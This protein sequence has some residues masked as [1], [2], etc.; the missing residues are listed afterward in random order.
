[1]K[2]VLAGTMAGRGGIQTHY[3]WLSRALLEGGHSVRVLSLGPALDGSDK[4]RETELAAF[5]D[6]EVICPQFNADKARV[7]PMA[8]GLRIL[9]FLRRWKPD[10]YLAC[11][12]GWNLFLP[13]ILGLRSTRT[14]HE[15]MSGVPT[16]RKDSRWAVRFGFNEVLAQAGPVGENFARHFGWKRPITVLPA[17]PEP[18]EVTG[19]VPEGVTHTVPFG[20][21]KAAF[22]SRLVPHKGALWLV[23]QW[24]RLS[25]SLK[26]L[27]IFGK[28]PEEGP[29]R[30]LI[31]SEGWEDKVFCHGPYPDGQDYIDLLTGF[32]LTLLPT[33]GAEGAPLVLL[34]SMACAVPFVAYGVGG[35]PDYTN[36]DSEI[37]SPDDPDSF[38]EAVERTIR[39]LDEGT[40]DHER[41]QRFYME[42]FSFRALKERW[43]GW[44]ES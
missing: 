11:G 35:I 30:E 15:V 25:Q 2:I 41:L 29:I 12:T 36:P 23:R 32:D 8:T 3:Q 26:E 16:G 40:L 14:F 39:R 4:A 13:A 19:N 33:T 22:F 20:Q 38:V 5:G 18:L 31:K 10:S 9:N 27:H 7:G 43:L 42:K 37:V 17:F 44:L 1:M 34:E 6:F 28:G 21:A 24:P